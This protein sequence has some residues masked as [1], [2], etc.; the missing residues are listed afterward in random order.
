MLDHVNGDLGRG[1]YC[2]YSINSLQEVSSQWK[3]PCF[4]IKI[5]YKP[6]S[7]A[8][9]RT[10][11]V[12]LQNLG[13]TCEVLRAL[14]LLRLNN[15]HSRQ[16]FFFEDSF[17]VAKISLKK[18]YFQEAPSLFQNSHNVPAGIFFFDASFCS[19]EDASRLLA[20]QQHTGR[21]ESLCILLLTQC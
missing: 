2:L 15:G 11:Q 8:E 20:G 5:I 21:P 16:Q 12:F 10:Q 9:Q 18:Q 19:W 4:L 6:H 3:K 7:L 14:T 1:R 13:Q 17:S